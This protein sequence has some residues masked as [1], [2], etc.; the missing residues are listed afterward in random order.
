MASVWRVCAA[1]LV[2]V[3]GVAAIAPPAV[4]GTA[5]V[6]LGLAAFAVAI[7]LAWPWGFPV[8]VERQ[9]TVY[10]YGPPPAG[11]TAPAAAPP[12]GTVVQY[13]HGRYE[14]R[15]D[16][17]AV[18]YAWVWIPNLPPPPPPPPAP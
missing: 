14:L 8:F 3:V 17:V 13:S 15:G 11:T 4:A 6:A 2:V 16:G 12:S 9:T 7:H 18:P 5:E 1:L 10:V